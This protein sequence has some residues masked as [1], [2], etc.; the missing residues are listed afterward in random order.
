MT[1]L[2]EITKAIMADSQN[3]VFTEK[4]IEPRLVLILLVKHRELRPKNRV[5]IGM[6]KVEIVCV[7]GWE[8]TMILFII[9]AILLLSLWIS[10]ILVKGNQETYRLERV[11]PRN[12]IS[13]FWICCL[14]F[15]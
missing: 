1:S 13:R 5:C 9:Q 8:W 15:S 4:N 12:G 3:K 10:I 7:S 6:I 2:E 11:L 14:I